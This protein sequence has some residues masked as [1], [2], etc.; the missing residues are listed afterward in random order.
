MKNRTI[1]CIAWQEYRLLW[2][3]RVFR[4]LAISLWVLVFCCQYVFQGDLASLWFMLALPSSMP[5]V[6]AYLV[7]VFQSFLVLFSVCEWRASERQAD[8]LEA[9]RVRPVGNAEY[10]CG[11]AIGVVMTVVVV[12]FV[13]IMTV[14]MLN[15][16]GSDSPFGGWAYLFYWLTLSVSGF[17]IL[18]RFIDGYYRIIQE[19]GNCL[20][21]ADSFFDRDLLVASWSGIRD[22][23]FYSNGFTERV[24]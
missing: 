3:N 18:H 6:N 2:R 13:S 14:F 5:F 7:S 19:A 17:G 8:S 10:L 11:K 23:R 4:L 21:G 24:F 16:F 1:V 15:L 22:F 9:I 20:V 12:Q